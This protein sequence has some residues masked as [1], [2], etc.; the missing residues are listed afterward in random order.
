[1][2]KHAAY[3]MTQRLLYTLSAVHDA[4]K[5]LQMR[6]LL[7][8]AQRS[9]KLALERCTSPAHNVDFAVETFGQSADTCSMGVVQMKE[10]ADFR[11]VKLKGKNHILKTGHYRLKNELKSD[12]KKVEQ[13]Q[14]QVFLPCTPCRKRHVLLLPCWPLRACL[15]GLGTYTHTLCV[16]ACTYV[17]TASCCC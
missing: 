17:E 6:L 11:E 10:A 1:M 14:E 16:M 5:D 15:K 12:H 4:A 13:L 2:C 3:V 8:E 9:Y 7:G